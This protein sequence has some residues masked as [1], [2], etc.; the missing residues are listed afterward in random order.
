MNEILSAIVWIVGLIV[1]APAIVVVIVGL[2]GAGIVGFAAGLMAM[3][4]W[5]ERKGWL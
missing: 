1:L 3:A 4:E 5:L 2:F